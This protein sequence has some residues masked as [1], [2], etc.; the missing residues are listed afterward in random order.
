[1]IDSHTHTS[2][3]KHAVGT[4]DDLVRSALANGVRIL[5]ITDHAPFFIDETNR[6][7]ECEL[8]KYFQDIDRSREKY[9]GQITILRGLEL[10]YFPGA[11]D[12]LA[13][14]VGRLDLDYVIGSIHYIPLGNEHVKVWDLPRLNNPHVLDSYFSVLEE[15]LK[16]GLFD[17][18]G[19]PDALLRG[20]PSDLHLERLVPLLPE[21]ARHH[22]AFELNASGLRKTTMNLCSG[23]EE[24]GIWSYPSLS[25]A[26]LL[27]HAGAAFTIG[28]DAHAPEDVGAGVGE[29]VDT[30]IPLGL[31]KVSYFERRRR[32]DINAA[33]LRACAPPRTTDP[34]RRA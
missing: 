9:E 20:V 15:L 13:K 7:L 18:V 5:T 22:I 31:E 33:D 34:Q 28:S 8:Q 25:T 11:Y 2:F 12:Y 24:H 26:S 10:D 3:S 32:I 30:L 19:H 17:A 4:V 1:M 6:L 16:C 23:K 21:F 14:M 29:V 27:I